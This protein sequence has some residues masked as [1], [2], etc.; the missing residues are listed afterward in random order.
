MFAMFRDAVH[1]ASESQLAVLSPSAPQ[2]LQP[3]VQ[4][5][6]QISP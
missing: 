3:S 1:Q 2:R 5:Y 6:Q 4:A